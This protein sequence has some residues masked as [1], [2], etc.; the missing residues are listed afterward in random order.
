MILW[1]ERTFS[2]RGGYKPGLILNVTFSVREGSLLENCCK[3]AFLVVYYRM[4]VILKPVKGEFFAY[5]S[6]RASD[7]Q[8]RYRCSAELYKKSVFGRKF[9]QNE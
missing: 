2:E 8:A 6:Y 9:H 7:K 4:T 5:P 3:R 1:D